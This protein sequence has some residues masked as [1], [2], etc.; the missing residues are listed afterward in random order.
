[1]ASIGDLDGDGVVDMIVGAELDDDGGP[2]RGAIY[3]LFLLVD[4]NVKS[5]QKISHSEGGFID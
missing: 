1:M 3:V 4:G 2:D 5:F